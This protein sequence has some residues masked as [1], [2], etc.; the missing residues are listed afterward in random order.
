ME[1]WQTCRNT[2]LMVMQLTPS[3][4][5]S[6]SSAIMETRVEVSRMEVFKARSAAEIIVIRVLPSTWNHGNSG[7]CRP[8]QQMFVNGV[9]SP[10]YSAPIPPDPPPPGSVTS[11][12]YFAE[13][14]LSLF[15]TGIKWVPPQEIVWTWRGQL[16]NDL[17]P[18]FSLFCLVRIIC[19]RSPYTN[20]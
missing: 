20:A 4:K 1:L 16:G 15:R 17:Y 8:R 12:N 9:L 7:S 11:R 5:V 14:T 6:L 13:E 10:V 2:N 3:R 18:R 19:S